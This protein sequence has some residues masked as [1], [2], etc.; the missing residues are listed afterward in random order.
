MAVRRRQGRLDPVVAKR[1]GREAEK[2]V[3][4]GHMA[5]VYAGRAENSTWV[6][7]AVQQKIIVHVLKVLEFSL[8]VIL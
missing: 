3:L 2:R 8:R 1:G 6:A 4:W 7:Y 5:A